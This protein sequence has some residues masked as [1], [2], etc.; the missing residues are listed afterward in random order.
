MVIN[1]NPV[2]KPRQTRSDI[3]KKRSVVMRY[4]KFADDLRLACQ[5]EEFHPSNELVMEFYLPMPKSWS[6]KKRKKMN[7][8]AHKQTP[9]IDNLAKSVMDSLMKNDACVHYLKA[10]KFWS[11]EGRI[12][13]KNRQ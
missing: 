4:R 1:I 13:L 11:E 12:V 3:W 5:Y 10:K 9:D 6:Q 2:S 8:K 7:G